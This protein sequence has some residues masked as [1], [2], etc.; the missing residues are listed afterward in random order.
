[1]KHRVTTGITYLFLFI[2]FI[3]LIP[4][5]FAS[6]VSNEDY[7]ES[8]GTDKIVL[9]DGYEER[10]CGAERRPKGIRSSGL[11]LP[12]RS[13]GNQ[14]LTAQRRILSERSEERT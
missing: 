5:F 7:I 2:I 3:I 14:E 6:C 13:E 10:Y 4:Q 12:Q 8:N 1:M 11:V 9:P